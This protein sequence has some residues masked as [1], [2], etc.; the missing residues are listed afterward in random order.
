MK[1]SGLISFLLVAIIAYSCGPGK[2]TPKRPLLHQPKYAEIPNMPIDKGFSEYISAYTSGV[3]AAN[4]VIEIRFTPEFASR[5]EKLTNGLFVFEPSIKG[6][7]EWKDEITLVFTPSRVLSQGTTYTGGLNLGNLATV[8]ERLR[9]FPIKIQT[10]KKEFRVSIGALECPSPDASAYLLNGELTTSDYFPPAEVERLIEA[11][12]SRHKMDIKWD[13]SANLVHK[14]T[15]TGIE[16]IV[17]VQELIISWDGSSSGIKQ[18]GSSLVIIPPTDYYSVLDII[19]IPGESQRIDII[20]SDPVDASMEIEGLI[21]LKPQTKTAININSNIVSLFPATPLSGTIDIN[22]ESSLRNNKGETL[23]SSFKKQLDFTPVPPGIILEGNGVIVPSSKNLIFPFKTANLKAVDLKIIMIYENNLP[24][25]LQQY[26][27]NGGYSV[28]RFGR[29]VYSGRVDLV[30]GS[31]KNIS[32]WNLYTIDLADYIDVKPGL[33]YKVELGMRKSYSLY[34]CDN[35]GEQSKYEEL[36]QQ[37]EQ[38]SRELWDDPDNYYEDIED[39]L[40]YSAGFSWRDRNDP[41]KEAYFSPDKKVSRNILASNLGLMAKQGDNDVL[42]VM[43]NDLLSAMPVNEVTIEVYDYQ[44]QL[45]ASGSTNQN[46]SAALHCERKPF[47]LVAK[48]D[49]DRNYLKTNDGSSLS[50]SSFDVAGTKPEDGIKAF[51]YGERDVWRPGDS[52][53][54][55]IFIKDMKNNLPA[56]HPVHFELINPL[57][58]RVDNQVQKAGKDKLLVFK[59]KTST[60]AVSGSYRAQIRIGG[61]TFTKRI[62]IETIKPNRLKINLGF[63]DDILGGTSPLEKGTLNVKWLNGSIAGKMNTS[64][65]YILKPS[66]TEFDRYKQYIFDDPVTR[67][68][69]EKV[70]IFDGKTDENGDAVLYFNPGKEINAPGMLNVVFTTRVSEPGGDESI[71]QASWKYAPYPIFAGINLPGLKDKSRMLF[72]DAEN[73]VKIVTVDENGKPVSS[74]AEITIYKI[75]Y[76]WWW[77]SDEEE[78]AYYISNDI[79]KPVIRE[80][81]KTSGGEGSLSFRIDKNEWGRYLIRVTTPAG[82]STGKIL[83]IDWPWEY[84]SK[85]GSEGA[86]LLAI[87]TDK[88]KYKPGDEIILSFPAPENSRAIITLENSTG[89]LEEMR[90]NTTKGNTVVRFRARPEMAPNIYAW[91]TVIQ[92]HA[93]TINDMPVR[94]YGIVP[95]MIE[96]PETRLSPAIEM[97]DELRSQKPFVIKVSETN[98]KPMTYTLAVVDEGLLDI[99]GY[100]TPDPWNYFFAREALGVKTWDLYDF[101]LGAFGGTLERIFAIGGDEALTDKAANKAQRFMPVVRFFGPFSLDAGKTNI[102]PLSLPQ[103][104]GSVRTMV[105]AGNDRSYGMAEKSTFVRDPL[106][107]LVTAPRVISPGEKVALPVTL[108][109]QKEGIRNINVKADGNEL[110]TFENN[111][112]D[113]KVS[114]TGEKET[115]FSF[116]AGENTGVAKLNVMATGGGESACYDMEIEVRSPNPPETRSELKLIKQGEKW[117]TR[118]APFGME[119]S[120]S[121][122]LEI[123]SL[124]SINLSKRMEYLMDYPHSCTE[125][126]ISAAF[127]QLWL[128]DLTG[129]D[130]DIAKNA[131]SNISGAVNLLIS[132]QMV[133]G[134][135]ALWP[136]SMQPDNWVSSYA[137]HFITEAERAGFSIPAG[138]KQKWLDYQKKTAREWRF[139]IHHKASASDQAYR[140]FT[141]ALAGNSEKGAMNRLRETKE[142]PQ[143]SHWLLAAAYA[144]TGRP[145]VAGE[146]LD[147]RNTSTEEEYRNYYYGSELRDKAIILYTLTLLKEEEAA[148][149]LLKEI[150]NNLNT[151]DWYSTQSVAWGLFSYMKWTSMNPGKEDSQSD[152]RITL[153]AEKSDLTIMR[154]QILN[155]SINMADEEN[156][157]TVENKSDKPLYVTLVRKGTPLVSDITREEKGLS[158]KIDYVNMEM[159]P[160]DPSNLNQGTDFMMVAKVSN[161]TFTQ[162][163]NIAL[164]QMVPSGWEIRNTRLFEADFGIKESRYDY[165]DFRDDRVNTYFSLARGETKNFVLILNAAY[166]GDY[167]QP[168]VWCEA[169]Y[170]PNC[171]S[172]YPGS[173]VTVTAPEFE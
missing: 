171:Y 101:V 123:S 60:D 93:Q 151:S 64:V 109:V 46:G 69:S 77:E 166:K 96:D 147:M 17:K 107:V 43:V 59:T 132:R 44:M 81:I 34:S 105:I 78:L 90:T 95:I 146:L 155:R 131:S 130:A 14:F 41:C 15:V 65:E 4:S 33:L 36:L 16:R 40:Y 56:G 89:V 19:S 61:A 156:S 108:F 30:P 159:N 103:Y 20:F 87:N 8:E 94:L 49:K 58:Q 27:I 18:K 136:G 149:P 63:N 161:N 29:P 1:A 92:P 88:E 124:P 119:G 54:L 24:Y 125:Q 98:K 152:I 116:T 72:T 13:H 164:T 86:T 70:N 10:L 157:L 113:I 169:M 173:R 52:I 148:L 22:V 76:R 172:R 102:H 115:E 118:F 120:N 99:T 85:G 138:F 26:D 127:P 82:H 144:I 45:V 137:G 167:Y 97:A 74:E 47:L 150:C 28:K 114:G 168:S 83:L 55:S 104:T 91:V 135:I 25:F 153:N 37:S 48:K 111:S 21:H 141:L 9:F 7:T 62:R 163:E 79:Y 3:V 67:F 73:E 129:N 133:N 50:L 154:G 165:R 53:F 5:A 112:A 143:L 84:G 35:P 126:I 32:G 75:S 42:N 128:K 100:R 139:D 66:K 170:M 11:K 134:G 110:V 2:E 145:E 39:A 12:I 57:E 121:A 106:M 38:E 142:I 140:L 6:K 162:I 117:E 31:G 68:Y 51:I 160:V 122:L 23:P 71:T 80:K 158:M